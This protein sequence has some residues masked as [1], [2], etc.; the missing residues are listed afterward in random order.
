M[1]A[2]IKRCWSWLI[3]SKEIVRSD[4]T[5]DVPPIYYPMW[6]LTDCVFGVPPRLVKRLAVSRQR[7]RHTQVG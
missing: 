7:R 3:T 6:L 5:F 1:Q 4:A 2:R